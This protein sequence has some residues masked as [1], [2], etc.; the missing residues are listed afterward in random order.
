MSQA[1]THAEF[2]FE[3]DGII[4]ARSYELSLRAIRK[5]QFFPLEK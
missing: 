2:P 5:S 3:V 4:Q 1:L